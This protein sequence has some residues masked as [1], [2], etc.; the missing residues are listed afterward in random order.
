VLQWGLRFGSI[1]AL[2]K[3]IYL[4]PPLIFLTTNLEFLIDDISV[5]FGVHIGQQPVLPK[6]SITFLT[7]LKITALLMILLN[8]FIHS[9][10]EWF[11]KAVTYGIQSYW[12]KVY[13]RSNFNRM[14]ILKYLIF[15][16]ILIIVLFQ[17]LCLSK[18]A[19][20]LHFIDH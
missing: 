5:E 6:K 9:H 16:I 2:P 20:F 10:D 19:T 8:V 14:W 4:S 15:W 18:Q 3:Y 13:L 7:M 17:K 1:Q 11:I 12:D